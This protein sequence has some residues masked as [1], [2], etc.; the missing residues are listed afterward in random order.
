[1]AALSY[2]L[3]TTFYTKSRAALAEDLFEE[4]FAW[5]NCEAAVN[6][7]HHGKYPTEWLPQL[8]SLLE[9][10]RSDQTDPK[11]VAVFTEAIEYVDIAML[12]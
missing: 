1:M 2:E 8:K 6:N 4:S 7:I 12:G 5:S 11:L 3:M 10:H 9:S